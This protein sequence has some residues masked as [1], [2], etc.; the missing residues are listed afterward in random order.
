MFHVHTLCSN[1]KG[2][3]DVMEADP[4]DEEIKVAA[5]HERELSPQGP[6]PEVVID[7]MLLA[8]Q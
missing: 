1:D 6:T 7:L 3:S 8:D 5:Q 4:D 2:S